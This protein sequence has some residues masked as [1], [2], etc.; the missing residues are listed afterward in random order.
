MKLVI[1]ADDVGYSAVNDIG[2]FEALEQGVATAADVMLDAPHAPQALE[3]LRQMPW[4]S[5]GWHP[6]FWCSPVLPAA[7]VPSL[8]QPNGRFRQDLHEAQDV[9]MDELMAEC[10][11]QMGLCLEALGRVPDVG[12]SGGDTPFGRA[13]AETCRQ[14]GMPTG[15]MRWVMGD[16]VIEPAPRWA[17]R[18]ICVVNFSDAYQAMISDDLNALEQY[19]PVR[20]YTEDQG[21]LLSLPDD[22]IAVQFWHPGYLDYFN[23]RQ[24]DYGPMAKYFTL[25]RIIDVHALCSPELKAWIR[26]TG[27]ELMNFR[28][29]LY[30]TRDYQNHLRQAG[31]PLF[32]G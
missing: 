31:S 20:Y 28:D 32:V 3:R 25:G 1:R 27:A 18:K 24:G 2:A 15:Y 14:Y 4:I 30:G 22:V 21:G 5:V 7:E 12:A 10:R 23:Y 6:H 26:Q 11:A 13:L 16:R 8:V 19:D 9:S 17:G 29:A